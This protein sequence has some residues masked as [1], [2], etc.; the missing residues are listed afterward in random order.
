MDDLERKLGK[1]ILENGSLDP[2]MSSL[3]KAEVLKSF[4][5]KLKSTKYIA[6]AFLLF[7]YCVDVGAICGFLF[8]QST[9]V[10]IFWAVV[11]LASNE[12]QV[13]MKLWYWVVNSKISVLKEIKRLEL[14]IAGLSSGTSEGGKEH[15]GGSH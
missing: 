6:W 3:L 15:V 11:V 1:A 14:Q 2:R 8:G 7:L 4:D 9:K 5:D 12:L 10:L 13:L